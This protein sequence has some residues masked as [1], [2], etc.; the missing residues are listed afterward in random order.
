MNGTGPRRV[1][2]VVSMIC[3]LPHEMLM[4][5]MNGA[6]P[7]RVLLASMNGAWPRRVL[8]PRRV[9]AFMGHNGVSHPLDTM[10]LP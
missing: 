10:V 2:L 3:N 6:R 9:G 1:L 5:S 4:A 7:R 8:L